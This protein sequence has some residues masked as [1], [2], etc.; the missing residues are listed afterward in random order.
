[1][2]HLR[3]E[4][5]LVLGEVISRVEC[6]KRQPDAS[7][8]TL[9][10]ESGYSLPMVAKYFRIK[11]IAAQEAHKLSLL[12][13]EGKMRVPA[14]YGL[15]ISQQMQMH[16]VLLIERIGGVS[17]E[18]PC[19]TATRWQQL[20]QQIVEGLLS[21]HKTDSHG[22]VGTVDSTQR[23]NWPAWYR[24]RIEVIWATLNYLKPPQLSQED[25]Q[26]LYRSRENLKA[27]FHGFDDPCVLVHGNLMPSSILKDARSDR[28]LAVV[29]PGSV[30]WAPREFDLHPL[31][32]STM[33]EELLSCYL[34]Q[35]PV[36]EEF[37]ARRWLYTLWEEMQQ[38]IFTARFDRRRFDH[39]AASLLPWLR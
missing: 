22:L 20:Q 23:N 29:S 7:L 9:Y 6:I 26:I 24:Q 31:C 35:A 33:G 2:E 11:D 27:L 16:E 21:W 10:D 39:A 28:L 13:R 5:A 1:M 18:A 12:S 3:N 14:I 30:L 38:L 4:L 25:R 17:I 32:G 37:V 8:Y 34:Q 36:A 15:V 19:R